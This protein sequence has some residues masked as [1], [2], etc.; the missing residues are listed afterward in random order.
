MVI[1]K[2]SYKCITDNI[3]FINNIQLLLNNLLKLLDLFL[4][5]II[6]IILLIFSFMFL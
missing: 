2:Y 5:I 3:Y 1:K 6:Y 4:K